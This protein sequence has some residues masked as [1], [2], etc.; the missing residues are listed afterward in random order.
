[1]TRRDRLAAAELCSAYA[2]AFAMG[3]P[4]SLSIFAHTL[5]DDS[6]IPCIALHALRWVANRHWRSYSDEDPAERW[7]LAASMLMNLEIP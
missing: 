6:E 1:M 3:A 5:S 2:S 7:A 4:P